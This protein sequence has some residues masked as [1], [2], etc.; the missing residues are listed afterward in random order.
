M[1]IS[2]YQGTGTVT[3]PIAPVS[4]KMWSPMNEAI[5]TGASEKGN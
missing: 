1:R 5:T 2:A 3:V 4:E